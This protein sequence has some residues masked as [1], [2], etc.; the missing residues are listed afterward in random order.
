M[1][2]ESIDIDHEDLLGM[3]WANDSLFYT[4]DWWDETSQFDDHPSKRYCYGGEYYERQFK[5]RVPLAFKDCDVMR[6][7]FIDIMAC[8]YPDTKGFWVD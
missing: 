4:H 5:A 3:D 8:D 1:A 6:D 2:D 7:R